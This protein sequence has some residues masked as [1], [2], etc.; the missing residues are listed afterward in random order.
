MT[1]IAPLPYNIQNGQ[2]VDAVPLMADL[3]QIVGNVNANAAPV[4]GNA[5]QT[6]QVAPATASN[7]AV[8]LGQVHG[9]TA[10]GPGWSVSNPTANTAYTKTQT[11]TAA[12]NSLVVVMPSIAMSGSTGAL[13]ITVNGAPVL[14]GAGFGT[15]NYGSFVVF[16]NV[17]S[18]TVTVILTYTP[19]N[20]TA[21]SI[22]PAVLILPTP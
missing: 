8:N 15:N 1:I 17:S 9:V 3:N 13:S 12:T 4:A 21:F 5:A 14:S 16:S 19:S 2:Q 18:G 10:G 6:F 7:Q 22:D 20:T 11:F